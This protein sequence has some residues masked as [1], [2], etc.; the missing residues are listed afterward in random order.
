MSV[1]EIMT[2]CLLIERRNLL[3]RNKHVAKPFLEDGG[4]A[5]R[6]ACGALNPSVERSSGTAS[7]CLR[8]LGL[9][10]KTFSAAW[11]QAFMYRSVQVT[12]AFCC[13]L[14]VFWFLK[15]A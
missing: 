9:T 12:F 14:S 5:F 8:S 6:P 1:W 4:M 2:L 10:S 13:L 15:I 11:H 7:I 3:A